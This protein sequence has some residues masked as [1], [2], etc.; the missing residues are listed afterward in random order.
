MLVAAPPSIP[1]LLLSNKALISSWAN[2]L[3]SLATRGS[4]VW[5][6][7]L[8][9]VSEAAPAGL[10]LAGESSLCLPAPPGFLELI[11]RSR[12]LTVQKILFIHQLA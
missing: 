8:S 5:V 10:T 7:S 1:L 3:L 9:C 12:H 6:V 4:G 2:C 11:R